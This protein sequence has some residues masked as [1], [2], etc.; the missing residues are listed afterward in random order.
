MRDP[1]FIGQ[2]QEEPK[3]P[4]NEHDMMLQMNPS[5]RTIIDYPSWFPIRQWIDNN[6]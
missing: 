3:V 2:G 1:V 6:I 5:N 4:R